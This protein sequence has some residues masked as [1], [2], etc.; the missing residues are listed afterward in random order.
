MQRI[1]H[2]LFFIILVAMPCLAGA[3]DTTSTPVPSGESVVPVTIPAAHDAR[4]SPGAQAEKAIR[5][6]YLD[7]VKIGSD[8]EQGKAAKA[9]FNARVAKYK[10]QIDVRQKQLE[11]QKK[12]IQAKFEGMSPEQRAVKAREFEKKVEEFQKY[13]QKAEKEMQ[14]LQE[15]ITRKLLTQIEQVVADYGKANDFTVIGVKKDVLY[16]ADGVDVQDITDAVLKLENEKER[17]P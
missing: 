17:N 2:I 12:A 6:G 16:L 5:F 7:M 9:K 4:P 8:S 10:S 1:R 3:D 13:V 11:K 15:D 14:D